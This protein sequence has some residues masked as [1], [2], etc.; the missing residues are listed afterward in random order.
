MDGLRRAMSTTARMA[1]AAWVAVALLALPA[2]AGPPLEGSGTGM[3]TDLEIVSER[4]AGPNS[5]QER[6]LEGV[7]F[8]DGP[9][10]GGT[11]VQE[12]TGTVRPDGHVTFRGTLVYT[13]PIGDCGTGTVTLGL[14]G[15]GTGGPA[16]VTEANV[17]VI[18]QPGN[19]ID[20]NGQ[21]TVTQDGPFLT[22]DIKYKCR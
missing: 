5:I 10:D 6:L 7:T 21:G 18:K 16:P 20:V 3:I 15:R 14:S 22:Y 8:G 12:V 17:R 1:V 2:G 4:Q 13:G 11:F 9:L 19:T